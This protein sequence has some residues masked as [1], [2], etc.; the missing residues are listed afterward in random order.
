[1]NFF[2]YILPA[3]FTLVF[4]SCSDD[5]TDFGPI[6]EVQD[7][8]KV[9]EISNDTHT[10]EVYTKSGT[11]VQGYNDITIR[12]KDKSNQ[13][14]IENAAISWKPV[15]HMTAMMHSCPKSE[16]LK[17]A[18]KQTTYNGFIIFQMPENES[19]GWDLTFNYTI[20]GISYEAV[21]TISI[22]QSTKKTVSVFTGTDGVK[23]V[24]ALIQPQNP[25][26]KI[27]DMVVGLYKMESMMSFPEVENYT[28][29][30]DPRMPSMGNHSSPN[31]EDLTFD[32]NS[33][34]YQ[35]KLSLTM[36]GYWK[37][38][39]MLRNQNYE[40]LKGEA[41]TDVNESSSLYLELEF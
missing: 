6:N 33:K 37:L 10:I 40:I 2:K 9:Q 23:Y 16:L 8:I 18:D 39:L 35:G 30:L 4:I 1:M 20:N 31:N 13:E 34:M 5:T 3:I 29:N 15:M 27:N 12:I 36:T 21:D 22:P 24:L 17:V 11:L 26:V 7:L 28:I 32:L 25:A 14:F 38:N 19:E 41:V